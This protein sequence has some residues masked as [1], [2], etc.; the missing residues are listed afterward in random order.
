SLP[1]AVIISPPNKNLRWERVKMLNL[2]VDFTL[3][4]S[5]L[6]GSLEFYTKKAVDLLAETPTDPTLGFTNVFA[7]AAEMQGRGWDFQLNSYNIKNK[8]I[9]WQTNL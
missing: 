6:N 4:D 3:L 2:G 8:A 7:N 9:T 5:R 1:T